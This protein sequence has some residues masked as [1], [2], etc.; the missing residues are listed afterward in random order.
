MDWETS[1]DY[2]YSK[3][4]ASNLRSGAEFRSGAMTAFLDEKKFKP[5]LATYQ[6]DGG[7]TKAKAAAKTVKTG[8]TAAKVA[9]AKAAKKGKK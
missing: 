5:G 1:N 9:P 2:I 8:K 3:T 7:K 6:K 4:D